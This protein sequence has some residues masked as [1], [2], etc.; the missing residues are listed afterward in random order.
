VTG[1]RRV[2]GPRCGTI[3]PE[4]FL[5]SI[6]CTVPKAAASVDLAPSTHV[7]YLFYGVLYVSVG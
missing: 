2:G 1:N 5:A 3:L 4:L 6:Y 7:S